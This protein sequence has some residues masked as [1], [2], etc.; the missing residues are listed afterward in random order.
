MIVHVVQPGETVRELATRYDVSPQRII[1]DNGIADEMRLVAGQALVIVQPETIHIVQ[2]GDTLYG[3]AR[4]Y[5]T[6]ALSLWQNNPWLS[7]TGGL[8]PGDSLV[9]RLQGQKRRAI[10]LGGYAYPSVDLNILK[11]ALPYLT[12]LTLFGYGFGEEGGLI[13]IDDQ[14]L[15]GLAYQYATAPVML[16]SSLTEDGSFSSRRASLLFQS[17]KLQKQLADNVLAA[18]LRKGYMGL[19]VDFEYI[20]AADAAGYL[21]FVT[22]LRERLGAYGLFVIT[23]LAPK[24]SADQP[25]LLY[26]AHDYAGLGAVSDQVLLMTYEWG[27]TYGPP[28]AVAPIDKVRQVVDYAV[29]E[30]PPAKILMGLPNYG[31]DWTLPFEQ[32][33]SRAISIGNQYAVELAA[34]YGAE[35][36]FDERAQT[37]YFHYTGRSGAEH[38]VWFEDA[39]SML[40]KYDLMDERELRGGEYWNLMRPFEQNWAMVNA[41]YDIRKIV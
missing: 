16:I 21:A 35:I 36:L 29:T 1:S 41:L 13:G 8:R 34:R 22:R 11:R 28:M 33:K 27:Y 3:I 6:T 39:R 14:P 19:A 15:I 38:V 12:T 24:T 32:G 7:Q 9:V 10:T 2:P 17:E 40:A 30:I 25:G 5:G 31:Y 26:E 18:M 37:P 4:Q 20:E 23:A